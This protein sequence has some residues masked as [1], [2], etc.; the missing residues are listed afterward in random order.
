VANTNNVLVNEMFDEVFNRRDPDACDRFFAR[1][2]VEHATAPFQ[3]EEPG[4]VDGP[5]HM[6]G[7]VAWLI[8]QH[9]DITMKVEAVVGEGDVVVA[10]VLSEGTNLGMLNGVIPPT[11]KRFSGYQSHWY[12]V[13]DGKLAEHW[14]VRDDLSTMLQL[15]VLQ[16]PGRPS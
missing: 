14:A 1:T 4:E 6:R 15:G 5:S 11:G 2:Y 12:R 10:R 9:P 3:N 8:D 7:V 16:R 13:H